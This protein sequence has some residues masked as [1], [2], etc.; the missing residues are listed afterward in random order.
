MFH[1][2]KYGFNIDNYEKL[3]PTKS[4]GE[5][6]D[7]EFKGIQ[8]RY[9]DFPKMDNLFHLLPQK[10]RLDFFT[11]E[12]KVNRLIPPHTDSGIKVTI[13]FYIRTDN[14]LTQFYRFKNNNPKTIQVNNQTD[15]YIFDENDLI[16]TKSFVAN[17]NE[18]W[19]LDVS[20]PHG[21]FPL[22]EFEE[23]VAITLAT[24]IHSYDDVCN[25]LYETGNL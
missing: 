3:L 25:M 12:M 10:Y 21:V 11:Q 7:G 6:V 9:V 5:V 17:P 23:R 14:C 18:V 16:K 13:N 19:V 15:G 24:P 8:Y 1:K 4:Y 22:G 20:Q 2:L